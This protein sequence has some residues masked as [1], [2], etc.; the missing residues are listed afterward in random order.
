MLCNFF[1]KDNYA[2]FQAQFKIQWKFDFQISLTNSHSTH[3]FKPKT[4]CYFSILLD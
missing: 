1:M 2:L 4:F 3:F